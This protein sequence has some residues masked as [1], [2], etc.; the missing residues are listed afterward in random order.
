MTDSAAQLK[1]A[2][3]HEWADLESDGT[4]RVGISDH[5]QSQLGD[6]VFLELPTV[7]RQVKRGEACAVI[8]SVK[9]ASDIHSPVSGEV[10]EVNAALSENPET[11]NQDPY[12]AWLFRLRVA[13]PAELGGLLDEAAYAAAVIQS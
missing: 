13:D 7:G 9:A 1:F 6:V 10:T 4:V 2:T 12:G 3:T 11:V 8:E 5:A